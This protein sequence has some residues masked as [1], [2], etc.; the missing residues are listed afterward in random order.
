MNAYTTAVS[1]SARSRHGSWCVIASLCTCPHLAEIFL[2]ILSS[3]PPVWS[4]QL[5]VVPLQSLDVPSCSA[6]C[7]TGLQASTPLHSYHQAGR[8][9]QSTQLLRP[10]VGRATWN[11]GTESLVRLGE[12]PGKWILV[13]SFSSW[14]A[15]VR[16]SSSQL[17]QPSWPWA[18]WSSAWIRGWKPLPWQE[19]GTRW[20]LRS[21]STQAI[22][23][24]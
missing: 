13:P 2:F 10:L 15:G 4:W 16:A 22:L 18:V 8:C 14:G 21:L 23:Q 11:L 19:A 17:P 12:R 24:F 9:E 7:T 20:S 1:P 5:Q 3:A 6:P